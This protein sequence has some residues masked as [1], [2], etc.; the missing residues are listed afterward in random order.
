MA[1]I[2]LLIIWFKGLPFDWEEMWQFF[3]DMW[4]IE[5]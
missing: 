5:K 2:I 1:I 4:S 3:I